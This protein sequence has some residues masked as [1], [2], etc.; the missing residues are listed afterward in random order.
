M[1]LERF[2]EAHPNSDLLGRNRLALGLLCFAIVASSLL[3]LALVVWKVYPTVSVGGLGSLVALGI[4]LLTFALYSFTAENVVPS[5]WIGLRRPES[6]A[7]ALGYWLLG[8]TAT[9]I[10]SI[11][12][13]LLAGWLTP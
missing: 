5:V 12:V 6:S 3:L 10:A 7:R 2:F 4:M 11:L 13:A 8:L 1:R 9:E